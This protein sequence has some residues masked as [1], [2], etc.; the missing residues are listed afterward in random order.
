MNMKGFIKVSSLLLL[1]IPLFWWAIHEIPI[2][3]IFATLLRLSPL[4]LIGLSLV[5]VLIL[6]LFAGRWL[7]VTRALGQRLHILSLLIYRLAGFGVSY[8]TP[9]PQF[10]G[11][12]LQVHLLHKHHNISGGA[13]LAGVSVDKMIEVLANFSFLVLGLMLVFRASLF[14]ISELF[15]FIPVAL[16]TLPL[17]YLAL[18]RFARRPVTWT[19]IRLS[20]PGK[21]NP[22]FERARFHMISA[23]EQVANIVSKQPRFL[24]AALGLSLITWGIMIFE[25]WFT[26]QLLG[27]RLELAQVIIALTAARIAFLLPIPAGLGALEAGQVAAMQILGLEPAI[28]ISVSLIIRARDFTLSSLGLGLAGLTTTRFNPTKLISEVQTVPISITEE[29]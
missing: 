19:L 13:A 15:L 10:G 29:R 12:P 26:L 11:E 9:G 20:L 3:E 21:W 23:E 22:A 1:S 25:Y 7:L 8:F 4:G 5:N 16:I 14:N 17:I 2:L 27:I 28:G 6:L 24:I 18:L